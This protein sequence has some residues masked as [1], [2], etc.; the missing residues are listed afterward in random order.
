MGLIWIG[1]DPGPS[2]SQTVSLTVGRPR[3]VL[4]RLHSKGAGLRAA[5]SL[6]QSSAGVG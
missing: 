6:L 5:V 3:D 2:K 4:G 1:L